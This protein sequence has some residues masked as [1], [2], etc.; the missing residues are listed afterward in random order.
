MEIIQWTKNDSKYM[1]VLY[2]ILCIQEQDAIFFVHI[3]EI[4]V[5]LT[6]MHLLY[7]ME[8]MFST[9]RNKKIT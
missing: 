3:I 6:Y 4:Y 9:N 5:T 7:F 2:T 1:H 8:K